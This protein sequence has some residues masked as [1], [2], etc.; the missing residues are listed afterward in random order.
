MHYLRSRTKV[1]KIICFLVCILAAKRAFCAA[2]PW[3]Q[4]D[5]VHKSGVI[6]IIEVSKVYPL[7][8][9]GSVMRPPFGETS[10]VIWGYQVA[11]IRILKGNIP[12]EP[13]ILQFDGEG[14]MNPF[15]EGRYL[16][17]L[18]ESNGLYFPLTTGFRIEGDTVNWY[19]KPFRKKDIEHPEKGP[20][21]TII[22]PLS[23]IHI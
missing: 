9:E 2:A 19:T 11:V 6:A 17:F 13:F 22:G 10:T 1:I 14:D 5:L 15:S 7:P 21:G 18:R 3:L 4:D 8:M 16:A 12:K 20:P 23:L